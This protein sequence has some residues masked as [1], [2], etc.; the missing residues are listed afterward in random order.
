MRNRAR[1]TWI[2][3]VILPACLAGLIPSRSSAQSTSAQMTV[4]GYTI[5]VNVVPSPATATPPA[6]TPAPPPAAAPQA[7]GYLII[8]G[9]PPI[10]IALPAASSP[11]TTP[12][13]PAVASQPGGPIV[14]NLNLTHVAQVTQPATSDR[15]L[16]HLERAAGSQGP[17][18]VNITYNLSQGAGR[19]EV[20][21]GLAVPNSTIPAIVPTQPPHPDARITIELV[22]RHQQSGPLTIPKKV[23]SRIVAKGGK[24]TFGDDEMKV[25]AREFI[26]AMNEVGAFSAANPIESVDVAITIKDDSG[27]VLDTITGSLRFVPSLIN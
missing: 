6:P 5:H 8:I 9:N 12:V 15:G 7:P 18:V 26:E 10:V 2:R 21:N 16:Y 13:V 20:V 4:G 14:I 24:F 17:A 1:S 22:F 23:R 11:T 25:I 19:N 3:L 27:T